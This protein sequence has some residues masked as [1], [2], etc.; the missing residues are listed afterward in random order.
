MGVSPGIFK[1]VPNKDG[2][3][4]RD[5]NADRHKID[6]YPTEGADPIFAA[7][8]RRFGLAED[9]P[10]KSRLLT[11]VAGPEGILAEQNA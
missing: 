5:Q 6:A 9:G 1:T 2:A 4:D 7:R 3:E 11:Y 8:W 10:S